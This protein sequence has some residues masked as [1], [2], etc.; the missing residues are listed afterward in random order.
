[1][2]SGS[3][4]DLNGSVN[5]INGS[6]NGLNGSVSDLDGSVNGKPIFTMTASVRQRIVEYGPIG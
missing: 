1:V 6:V 5:G 3:V 2:Q 4:S